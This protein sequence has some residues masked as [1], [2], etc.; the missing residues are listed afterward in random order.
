MSG[1]QKSVRI[2]IRGRV[3]EISKDNIKEGELSKV[4]IKG[5]A[6]MYEEAWGGETIRHLDLIKRIDFVDGSDHQD[7]ARSFIGV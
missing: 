4:T 2:T 5:V 7:F 6:T 1:E 3:N